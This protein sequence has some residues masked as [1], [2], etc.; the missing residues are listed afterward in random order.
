[1]NF[2]KRLYD[3]YLMNQKAKDSDGK[4]IFPPYGY[5]YAR[6][7]HQL[8]L[9]ASGQFDSFS[10]VD[11]DVF[12]PDA[13]SPF[14]DCRTSK[15]LPFPLS[16]NFKYMFGGCFDKTKSSLETGVYQKHFDSFFKLHEEIFQATGNKSLKAFLKFLEDWKNKSGSYRKA[17][18]AILSVLL[19]SKAKRDRIIVR[20][21][22]NYL[23]EQA[24]LLKYWDKKVNDYKAEVGVCCVTGDRQPLRLLHG[25]IT[26]INNTSVSGAPLISFNCSA[27]ESYSGK[28]NV[29][30]K[31]EFGYRTTLNLFT[32]SDP[33]NPNKI[34]IGGDDV[35]FW[36]MKH[37][38]NLFCH[39]I[40]QIFGKEEEDTTPLIKSA[41]VSV[42]EG[43]VPDKL[44]GDDTFC[45][46]ILTGNNGRIFV[47]DV[48]EHSLQDIANAVKQHCTDTA[49]SGRSVAPSLVS[50]AMATVSGGSNAD[51]S[52]VIYRDLLHSVLEGV[53]YPINAVIVALN[54]C[55]NPKGDTSNRIALI[56]GY[57]CRK[58]RQEGKEEISMALDK[59]RTSVGYL[60][61]RF[62]A[63]GDY[64]Q[65]ISIGR[66]PNSGLSDTY[67]SSLCVT[68]S[69]VF[70]TI[71]AKIDC[72][73]S[74][75]KRN[76]PG[77]GIMLS[78][79]Y[80]SILDKLSSIPSILKFDEQAEFVLGFAHQT[81][82]RYTKK[83][84]TETTTPLTNN[85][86]AV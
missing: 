38:D 85:Q 49:W 77:F 67:R 46:A 1:M 65:A 59:N 16:D 8:N 78:R 35:V 70:S 71:S 84:V 62:L 86:E 31:V 11:K 66:A 53:Q 45:L 80:S 58:L 44:P 42:R 27:H 32:R 64:I 54:Y 82:D 12:L 24:D 52:P 6:A 30:C 74:K 61:G 9:T 55:L 18:D 37:K 72:H 43:R 20:V 41:L 2:L 47:R 51:P 15:I 60:L 79:E 68:P 19:S 5:Y 7:S 36:T 13:Q 73:L 40:K 57:L 76:T 26:G 50:L 21:A 22:G 56:K 33:S 28:A 63:M 48:L 4:N 75:I 23:H 81:Q 69:M 34:R 17:Y 39:I 3:Y 83:S 10:N 25:K 14:D 29:G